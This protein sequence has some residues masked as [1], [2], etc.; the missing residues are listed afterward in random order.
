M[1]NKSIWHTADEKPN[2]EI[3]MVVYYSKEYDG[4]LL[5]GYYNTEYEDFRPLDEY[6][7]EEKTVKK[8]CYLNDLLALETEN[9]D[10]S[11]KIGKLEIELDRTRKAL[12]I[13]VDAL[14]ELKETVSNT[15][16]ELDMTIQAANA[17]DQ[18]T[19]LKQKD[20]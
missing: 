10:L 19:A 16:Q 13:A 12:E 9:K 15:E 7:C 1:Q 14:K 20:K 18:I 11:D 5:V 3:G 2:D 8:W 17:L 4:E 6:Y